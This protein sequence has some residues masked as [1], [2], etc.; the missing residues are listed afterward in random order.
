[1]SGSLVSNVLVWTACETFT[2]FV[3]ACLA[4]VISVHKIDH[5]TIDAVG[6]AA[7]DGFGFDSDD[8]AFG[9][10][11]EHGGRDGAPIATTVASFQFLATREFVEEGAMVLIM[12]GGGPGLTGSTG[13]GTKGVAALAG[14]AGRVVHE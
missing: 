6:D 13:R 11:R 4:K 8:D 10:A 14:F 3:R 5:E 12:P 7:G 9:E 2:D 1:V